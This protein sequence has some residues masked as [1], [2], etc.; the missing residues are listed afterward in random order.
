MNPGKGINYEKNIHH[1]YL[2]DLPV[3]IPSMG[4]VYLPTL[5]IWLIFM[6]NDGKCGEICHTWMI[7]LYKDPIFE[8]DTSNGRYYRPAGGGR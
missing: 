3:S 5:Y 4:L 2:P 7:S 8:D 1:E 6:I